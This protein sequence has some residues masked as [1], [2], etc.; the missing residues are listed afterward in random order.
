MVQRAALN[1]AR[2]RSV[3]SL[4]AGG[5]P[6][7]TWCPATARRYFHLPGLHAHHEWSGEIV[8]FGRCARTV[9]AVAELPGFTIQPATED[10]VPRL[11]G[12]I[13]DLAVYEK[14]THEVVAT[15][16]SLREALFGERPAAAGP[17]GLRGELVAFRPMTT[18]GCWTMH[19]MT[20][21]LADVDLRQPAQMCKP[22]PRTS[23][24]QVSG[25]DIPQERDQD[26]H[27]AG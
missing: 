13:W 15:E 14:L 9:T 24:N 18:D 17:Q 27:K 22:C 8:E 23:V 20:D 2:F 7:L 1:L 5:R 6:H 11:L 10:D 16:E 19:F 12:L 4:N 26:G 25:L 21:H 3:G